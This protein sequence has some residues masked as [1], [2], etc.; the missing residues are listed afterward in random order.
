MIDVKSLVTQTFPL[1]K[2]VEG[3]KQFCETPATSV[4]AVMVNE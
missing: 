3:L 2:T 4:K 1:E